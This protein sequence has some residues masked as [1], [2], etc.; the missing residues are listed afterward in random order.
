VCSSDLFGEVYAEAGLPI[1]GGRVLDGDFRFEQGQLVVREAL[2]AGLAFD[3]VFAHN[4]L[5]AAGALRALREAGRRVPEDVAV[6]GFDDIPLAE[7]TDPP[8][9]TVHQP[10]RELGEAATRMLLARLSGEPLSDTPTV[11]PTTLV[12]RGTTEST[13]TTHAE[14]V[15]SGA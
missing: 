5:S 2:A 8:L 12:V 1:E 6:V 14:A 4:D 15:P 9:T 13:K 11:I 3:A 7:Q 10:L